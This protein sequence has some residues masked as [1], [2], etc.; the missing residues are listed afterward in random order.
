M[1]ALR[2]LQQGRQ[3]AGSLE[4]T[5]IDAAD[6]QED[7][8]GGD[9]E[10]EKEGKFAAATPN[11]KPTPP[12]A[13]SPLRPLALNDALPG[14]GAAVA[15]EGSGSGGGDGQ[16]SDVFDEAEVTTPPRSPTTVALLREEEQLRQEVLAAIKRSAERS[17]LVEQQLA[18]SR[19]TVTIAEVPKEMWSVYFLSSYYH[20]TEYFTKNVYIYF[21][22]SDS[23]QCATC[24]TRFTFF[25]RQHHCRACGLCVCHKCSTGTH[26]FVEWTPPTPL[27]P[28]TTIDG[29]RGNTSGA[30]GSQRSFFDAPI[31]LSSDPK[32]RFRVHAARLAADADADR[33][34]TF[35]Y[36]NGTSARSADANNSNSSNISL[37]RGSL[38]A[39]VGSGGGN[40]GGGGAIVGRGEEGFRSRSVMVER[41]AFLGGG[42]EANTVRGGRAASSGGNDAIKGTGDAASRASAALGAAKELGIARLV[43]EGRICDRCVLRLRKAVRRRD[44]QR[45]EAADAAKRERKELKKKW[46]RARKKRLLHAKRSIDRE[47]DRLNER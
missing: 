33:A 17:V 37:R 35:S 39:G 16:E 10:G 38:P 32:A 45:K 24:Y 4:V 30:L 9:E 7:I 5:S 36:D 12:P 22:R 13:N 47:V 34:R 1:L 43:R 44:V 15:R 23:P 20:V 27:V 25:N 6:A 2:E 11:F 8:I 42:G 19:T 40:V 28:Q 31:D 14:A 18:L 3:S 41:L 29:S 46:M 26:T 21:C